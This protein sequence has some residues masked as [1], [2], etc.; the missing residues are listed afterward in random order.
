M[1]S[2][3]SLPR[4]SRSLWQRGFCWEPAAVGVGKE[5]SRVFETALGSL[6]CLAFRVCVHGCPW[7]GADAR[8]P[9][10]GGAHPCG[11]SA[12]LFLLCCRVDPLLPGLRSRLLSSGWAGLSFGVGG[13]SAGGAG[14][15]AASLLV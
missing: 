14:I 13:H 2:R 5:P 6:V 7:V 4:L 1:S 15:G 8:N 12:P 10:E 3:L 9:F 11:P